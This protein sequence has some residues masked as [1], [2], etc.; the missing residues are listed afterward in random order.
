MLKLTI[1]NLIFCYVGFLCCHTIYNISTCLELAEICREVNLPPGV[2][3][4]VTGLGN[5]AGA[6]LA[7]HPDVDKVQPLLVI[8]RIKF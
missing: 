1:A 5:E 2:L 7:S 6:P 3:N 8:S 4:V